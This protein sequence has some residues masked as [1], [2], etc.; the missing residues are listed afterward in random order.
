MVE[1]NDCLKVVK[2]PYPKNRFLVFL[3]SFF[4]TYKLFSERGWYFP[5]SKFKEKFFD[6]KM[7]SLAGLK[8]S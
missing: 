4:S 5:V 1:K 8:K 6:E 3:R 7:S 2:F